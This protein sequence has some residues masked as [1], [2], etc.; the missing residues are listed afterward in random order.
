MMAELRRTVLCRRTV[1]LFL[2]MLLLNIVLCSFQCNDTQ[3]ITLT[4]EEL[5]NYIA[6]YGEYVLSTVERA[7]VMTS[8]GLMSDT[9]SYTYRNIVKTGNDFE[10]MLDVVPIAGENRGVVLFGQFEITDF[11]LVAFGIYL[12]LMF[13]G[14]YRKGLSLLTF[15]TINGRR[16]LGL[17]RIVILL[18]TML[19]G[20]ILLYLSNYLL[21][22]IIYPGMELSR[23]IQSV[24]EFMKCTLKLN[25]GQYM[26]FSSG[27]R[28]LGTCAATL[29]VF[30]LIACF[31]NTAGAVAGA[32]LLLGEF[33][34]YTFINSTSSFNR[35][36]FLNIYALIG[37]GDIFKY[38]NL[39]FFGRPVLLFT[40]MLIFAVVTIVLAAALALFGQG[41]RPGAGFAFIRSFIDRVI[42]FIE[43]RK[44]CYSAFLWEGRKLLVTQFG[45][46]IFA[47]VMYLAVSSSLKT[48]YRDFRNPIEINYYAEFGGDI[49]Q[50]KLNSA[51]K[52]EKQMSRYLKNAHSN[53]DRCEK[54]LNDIFSD[55]T[56]E[57]SQKTLDSIYDQMGLMQQRIT[58]YENKLAP[59]HR[60]IDNMQSAFATAKERDMDISL[61]EP[62]AYDM[63]LREDVQTTQKAY[64][65]CM[66]CIVLVLSGIMSFERT[67]G[68]G[69]LLGSL[70][71][72]RKSLLAGKAV[73]CVLVS[74]GISIPLHLIQFF[75][76]GSVFPYMNTEYPVQ[77]I[78]LLRDFP[79]SIS[80]GTYLVALYALRTLIAAAVGMVVM[81]VSS[82][83]RNRV[84]CIFLCLLGV[85]VYALLILI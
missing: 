45:F 54:Q 44:P 7:E 14:E 68:V 52:L 51:Q 3:Q 9:G 32:M 33:L 62:F 85:A 81:F 31:K 37:R 64:L 58:E 38:Y 20:A 47:V 29:V 78:V 83:T 63:L 4:G 53:Y 27:V 79:L 77:S 56:R 48:E 59:L 73:W 80:L 72:G 39:V 26:L 15:S 2:V 22:D 74:A 67:Q 55:P 25:I 21:V 41:N 70:P 40:A 6:Q 18:T 65:Y 69:L 23:P 57:V 75:R 71:Y 28:Y 46:V 5:D 42:S 17:I 19:A 49:S 30:A 24:P 35:L 8:L 16:R 11:L 76:I 43:H 13:T 1:L 82:R 60:V 61:V 50:E 10:K 12:V 84:N 66:I 34:V 36:K